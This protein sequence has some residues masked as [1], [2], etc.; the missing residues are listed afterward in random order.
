MSGRLVFR[1]RHHRC[2][3]ELVVGVGRRRQLRWQRRSR[4]LANVVVGTSWLFVGESHLSKAGGCDE[5]MLYDCG[6]TP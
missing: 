4:V 6:F 2:H 1:R 3:C 5:D